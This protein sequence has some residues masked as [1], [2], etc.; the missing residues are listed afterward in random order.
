[1]TERPFTRKAVEM[2]SADSGGHLLAYYGAGPTPD[3]VV[4]RMIAGAIAEIDPALDD[5]ES[6][7]DGIEGYL[8]SLSEEAFETACIGEHSDILAL[9]L[10]GPVN[11]F[12]NDAFEAD[13]NG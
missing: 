7:L 6:T 4:D 2:I 10:P 12:L 13:V 1:M 8:A 11:K 5:V 9:S 3:V